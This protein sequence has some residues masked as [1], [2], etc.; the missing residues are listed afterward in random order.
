MA[1]LLKPFSFFFLFF[2]FPNFSA[3]VPVGD[4]IAELGDS[5]FVVW[6]GTFVENKI[7]ASI[8]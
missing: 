2:T 7:D 8:G 5:N 6:K 4:N 3:S 1:K